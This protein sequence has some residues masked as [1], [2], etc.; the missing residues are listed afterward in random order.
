[1][2][3]ETEAPHKVDKGLKE[4]RLEDGSRSRVDRSNKKMLRRENK[5]KRKQPQAEQETRSYWTQ[6]E[7]RATE[8]AE[9]SGV[10]E[11]DHYLNEMC[12]KGLALHHPAAEK[13]LQYATRGCPVNSG[14]EWTLEMQEAAIA[15]WPH[16]S[17]MVPEAILISRTRRQEKKKQEV[18]ARLS[19]GR[20]LKKHGVPHQL[21]IS[22]LA[23]IPHKSRAFRAILD[24]SFGIRLCDGRYVPSVNDG[25]TLE[26][27]SGAIDQLGH[28]LPR[29]IKMVFG[30]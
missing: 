12:P 23:M 15:R 9:P 22:P 28:S 17:A 10:E 19:N 3:A 14:A 21:K 24:L 20:C 26:A 18:N 4:P 16:A 1:M 29:V 8:P 5:E 30:G 6:Y 25:T 11:L 7:G 13:L 27:P 2:P